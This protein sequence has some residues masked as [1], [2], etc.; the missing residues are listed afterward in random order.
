M[1]TEFFVTGNASTHEQSLAI[2][3]GQH[4]YYLGCYDDAGNTA[5]NQ[6]VFSIL[7][8]TTSPGIEHV[9]EDTSTSPSIIR[10]ELNEDAFCQY[11]L[12]NEISFGEG[13]D[14]IKDGNIHSV[15]GGY[16]KYFVTCK[17]VY[18]NEMNRIRIDII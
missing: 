4:T 10:V 13:T 17:D 16:P 9:Y 18:G 3:P 7:A 12:E 2:I 8:D 6:T 1:S 11:S 15:E 5:Y 14:M